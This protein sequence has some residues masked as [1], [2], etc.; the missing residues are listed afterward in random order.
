[1]SC[2][3]ERGARD[4][5]V[6][7]NRTVTLSK[8]PR[9]KSINKNS[10]ENKILPNINDAAADANVAEAN[11]FIAMGVGAALLLGAA[12]PFCR[13]R[14]YWVGAAKEALCL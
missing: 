5:V 9:K 12:C 7:G 13:T 14:S 4:G 10:M 1:M 3:S 6:D 11:Q 2:R 8:T